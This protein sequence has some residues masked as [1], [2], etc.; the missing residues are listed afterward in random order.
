MSQLA[1]SFGIGFALIPLVALTSNA[2]LMGKFRNPGWLQ[3]LSWL[4][5]VAILA[6]NLAVILQF[7]LA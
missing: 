4:C 5:A 1:L 6:L 7:A 2:E 3:A